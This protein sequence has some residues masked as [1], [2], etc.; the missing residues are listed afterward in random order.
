MELI[1]TRL[2]TILY[3]FTP[4][5]TSPPFAHAC[6]LL[7]G[8]LLTSGRR[9]V[10]SALRAIGHEQDRHFTTY[11]RILNHAAWSPLLLSRLL[12]RLLLTTFWSFSSACLLC[13]V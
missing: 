7:V 12:L 10:A 2:L 13:S 9:T 3:T 6:D 8:T 5:F 1:P 4:A 11:H